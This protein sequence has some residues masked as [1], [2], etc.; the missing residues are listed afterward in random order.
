MGEAIWRVFVFVLVGV[1]S[2]AGAACGRPATPA[3]GGTAASEP[4]VPGL[5]EMMSLQQMRHAKLWLAGQAENWDLADYEIDELGEGF[6]DIVKYHPTHKDSPVAPRDAIPRMVTEPLKA[7]RAA[8]DK[9]DSH[10]FEQ[11]YDDFTASC[12][13]CH[14]A[15]NFSFNRVQRPT[16]NPYANQVFA[17]PA[18]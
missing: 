10:A 8:V 15:T 17:R 12:N 3:T 4:Y 7:L 2:L 9:K 14:Q 16:M 18:Q 13:N 5:G 1:C 6:D 11:A